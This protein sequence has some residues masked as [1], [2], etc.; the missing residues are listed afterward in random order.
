MNKITK[1]YNILLL[2]NVKNLIKVEIKIFEF[3]DRKFELFTL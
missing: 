1:M 3:T 2:I